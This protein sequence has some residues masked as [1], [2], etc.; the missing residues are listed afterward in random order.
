MSAARRRLAASPLGALSLRRALPAPKAAVALQRELAGRVERR[1]R[2]LVRRRV[3]SSARASRARLASELATL[4]GADVSVRGERARAAVVVLELSSLEVVETVAVEGPLCFPYVPG[5]LSFREVPLLLEAFDRLAR[6]PELVIV[7]GHGLAHPRRLGIACHLGLELDLPTIGCAKS[8]LVGEH[9]PP[10]ERRGARTRLVHRGERV[11]T[12]LRTRTG[13]RP[14]YLSIGHRIDLPRAE[15]VVLAA[16][17]GTRLPRPTHLADRLA[18][19][20]AG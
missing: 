16:G 20:W 13:V 5:L 7:D 6:R 19:E 12:C 8:L 14:V 15:R 2:P 4:A 17:A 1:W 3:P 18:G 11:G 10:G 9:R